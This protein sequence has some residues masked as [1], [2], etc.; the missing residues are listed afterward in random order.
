M[1][2]APEFAAQVLDRREV[3][4]IANNNHGAA[5]RPSRPPMQAGF[6][7][8]AGQGSVAAH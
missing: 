8:L 4:D 5:S 6:T 7:K 1:S 3:Y 2:S